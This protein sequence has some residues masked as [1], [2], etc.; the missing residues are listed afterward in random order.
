[1]FLV[2]YKPTFMER[3]REYLL[4]PMT[5]KE[6]S[7]SVYQE[8]HMLETFHQSRQALQNTSFSWF[9]MP[10]RAIDIKNR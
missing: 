4:T 7:S 2:L 10:K 8:I 5:I 1:M 3:L 6:E 9:S